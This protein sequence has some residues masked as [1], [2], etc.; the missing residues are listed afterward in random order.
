MPMRICVIF[1]P[2]ARGEKARYFRDHLATLAAE[3]EL[4]PT[5]SA[6]AG[7]ALAAEA[8][9]ERFEIIVAAGGDGTVNEVLNGIGN[10]PDG[11][12]RTRFAVLPLG[13]VN[14]FA[15]ELNLPA[16][17]T[18][19]WKV[20]KQAKE[21]RIDIAEAEFTTDGQ[22]QRRF[23]AQMAGAGLDTR[24]IEMVD[25]QHKKKIGPLAYV[26]AGIRA[27][28]GPLPQVVATDGVISMAGELVLIGNGRYYGGRFPLFPEADAR[29]G[30]LEVSVF[31]KAN[32]PAIFRTGWGLL[33]NQL[34]GS[35]G[36]RHFR[37][38]SVCLFS[39]VTVP[40][41]LAGEKAGVLPVRFSVRPHALRII[42]P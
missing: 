15:K 20:I 29:D 36:V 37:A 17:F 9:R 41:N 31:P 38:A 13:T 19:A 27:L 5:Y 16:N 34:Y 28:R 1:T 18:H 40:F 25:W 6:G 11:F 39:P 30:L 33:T 2:A 4:K 12:A 42:V 24:A 3:C 7:R 23:F 32:W 26:I 10:E 21:S 22:T 14:V 35:G 8:V